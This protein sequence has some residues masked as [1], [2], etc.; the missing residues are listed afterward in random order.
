MTTT[1]D[2]SREGYR[3]PSDP[4]GW[5]RPTY[6]PFQIH[7]HDCWVCDR[8]SAVA[9]DRDKHSG[10]HAIIAADSVLMVAAIFAQFPHL[11]VPP[12]VAEKLAWARAV[13]VR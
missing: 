1:T 2:A 9:E 8:C 13:A 5:E 7:G 6:T 3:L 4:P 11:P 10:W 12:D